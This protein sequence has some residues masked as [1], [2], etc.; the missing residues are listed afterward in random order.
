[1]IHDGSPCD[2]CEIVC[3]GNTNPKYQPDGESYYDSKKLLN[4]YTS[5]RGLYSHFTELDDEPEDGI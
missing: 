3:E 5:L 4:P 1:M 2:Y